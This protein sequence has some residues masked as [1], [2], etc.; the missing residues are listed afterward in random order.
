MPD[1]QQN[2]WVTRVFVDVA[3]LGHTHIHAHTHTE[4]IIF[5]GPVA[6]HAVGTM[7]GRRRATRVE[8]PLAGHKGRAAGRTPPAER[9]VAATT[10]PQ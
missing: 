4:Q 3:R 2:I 5:L 1:T 7:R 6:R 9:A 10:K 8:R